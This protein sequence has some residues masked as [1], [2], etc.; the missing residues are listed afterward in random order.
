MCLHYPHSVIFLGYSLTIGTEI[1][2][3]QSISGL[4]QLLNFC[5]NKV[6][7]RRNW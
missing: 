2:I 6:E 5:I 4:Q 3:S 1:G 7:I